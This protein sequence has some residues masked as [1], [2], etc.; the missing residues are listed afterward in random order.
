[1]TELCTEDIT[2]NNYKVIIKYME[3]ALRRLT[4]LRRGILCLID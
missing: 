1:M 4:V 3:T 2:E